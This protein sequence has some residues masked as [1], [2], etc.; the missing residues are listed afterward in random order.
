MR[1]RASP[2]SRRATPIRTSCARRS[3]GSML[4]GARYEGDRGH[5]ESWFVKANDPAGERALWLKW[6]IFAPKR[7]PKR[8]IAEAWAVAFVRKGEHVA[9]KSTVPFARA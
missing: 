1:A 6:T 2:R 7:E 5:V 9:V 8:A 4:D 3:R